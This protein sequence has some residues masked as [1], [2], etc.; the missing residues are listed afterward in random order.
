MILSNKNFTGTG[1]DDN[2]TYLLQKNKKDSKTRMSDEELVALANKMTEQN[3]RMGI[4]TKVVPWLS[5]EE[6]NPKF[7]DPTDNVVIIGDRE[8]QEPAI[9]TLFPNQA[10]NIEAWSTL[11]DVGQAKGYYRMPHAKKGTPGKWGVVDSNAAKQFIN[12]ARDNGSS[13]K[14]ALAFLLNH[15]SGHNWVDHFYG[16][17][18][19]HLG[20]GLMQSGPNTSY[21]VQFGTKIGDIVSAD[22]N[23]VYRDI[24]IKRRQHGDPNRE[25]MDNYEFNKRI[26]NDFSNYAYKYYPSNYTQETAYNARNRYNKPILKAGGKTRNNGILLIK[27]KEKNG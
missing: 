11:S 13:A 27:N 1:K 2:I 5:S 16:G 19:G 12:A 22:K 10:S 20:T 26:A 8:A 7:M 15:E 23:K 9:N 14:E 6:F 4:N 21:D 17:D 18:S 24:I 3:K 25:A